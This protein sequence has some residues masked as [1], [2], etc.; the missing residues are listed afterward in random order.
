MRNVARSR[1]TQR[2]LKCSRRVTGGVGSP[3][4]TR[5]AKATAV[6]TTLIVAVTVDVPVNGRSV[7]A[8][9]FA[10]VGAPEH[11]SVIVPL[12]PPTGVKVSE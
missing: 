8:V 5:G 2:K 7:G 12:K 6:V 4:G 9:Q 10:P 3:C 11:A 1:L